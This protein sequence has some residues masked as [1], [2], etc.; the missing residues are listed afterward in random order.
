[1]ILVLPLLLIG[2]S[3]DVLSQEQDSHR[4]AYLLAH[5]ASLR[6]L[7]W[8]RLAIRA[9]LAVLIALAI[10][11]AALVMS[12]GAVGLTDRLP[13]FTLWASG[14]V[15]YSAFWSALIAW[16]ASGNLQGGQNILRLLLAWATLTLILPATLVT[17]AEMIHPIPSRPAYLAQARAIEVDTELAQ[18]ESIDRY[19][20]DHPEMRIDDSSEVPAYFRIAFLV[21][22][23]VDRATRPT[24]LDFEKTAAEREK[25]LGLLK[26]LSPATAMYAVFNQAAGTS[27]V[28]HREYM[29]QT[30]AFK[31]KYGD[32]A[33]PYVVAGRRLPLQ[34]AED[35]PRFQF[36]NGSTAAA[37]ASTLGSLLF[38]LLATASLYVLSDR[39]IRCARVL[40]H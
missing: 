24:L 5:G 21:T 39:R 14:A 29:A 34:I 28:R 15:L 31:A 4:L 19:A 36:A 26:Y 16:V 8:T 17:F 2:L 20:L 38:V 1:V 12:S 23:A 35:L 11:V 3:F 7:L 10:A 25:V 22:S 40:G 18:E 6:S 33:G 9:G 27:S 37:L 32:R 30:R 13:Y